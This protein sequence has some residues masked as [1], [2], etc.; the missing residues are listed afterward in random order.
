MKRK[1][2]ELNKRRSPSSQLRR[3]QTHRTAAVLGAVPRSPRDLA[4]RAAHAALRLLD[5]KQLL[6]QS[7]L[8]QLELLHVA[9]LRLQFLLQG[10][11]DPVLG[12]DFIHLN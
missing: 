9:C 1:T 7:L 5:Q 11:D 6:V 8:L 2:W 4:L 10:K 12:F 3:G